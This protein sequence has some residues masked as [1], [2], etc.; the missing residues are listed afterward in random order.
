MSTGNAAAAIGLANTSKVTQVGPYV[1]D[2]GVAD[3]AVA[4][5]SAIYDHIGV[6]GRT[7]Y[8]RN[9]LG[10][11]A[12]FVSESNSG[13]AVGKDA[14]WS[15]N[16]ALIADG[17]TRVGLT[18]GVAVAD[19]ATGVYD[20]FLNIPTDGLPANSWFWSFER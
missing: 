5:P 15:T 13:V 3:G 10:E 8:D 19:N 7:Y 14:V 12:G 17:T 11:A 1:Q 16:T 2:V 18:V 20:I 6:N 9:V 4:G